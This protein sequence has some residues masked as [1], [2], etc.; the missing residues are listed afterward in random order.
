MTKDV[1]TIDN[2]K[3]DLKKV[4]DFQDGVKSDSRLG[5]IIPYVILSV[6]ICFLFGTLIFAVIGAPFAGYEITKYASELKALKVARNTLMDAADR[7]DIYIS[8]ETLSHISRE[9]V[10]EPRVRMGKNISLKEASIYHFES[11]RSWRDPLFISD[12]AMGHHYEWS[13]EYRISC[14][15]LDNISVKGNE[16]YFISLQMSPD[17]TYIYPTKFFELSEELKGKKE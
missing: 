3:R 15:G 12:I 16:F 8:L 11:G 4:I 9:S 14:I 6:A 10:Y 17:V 1:L 2:V 5:Y 7:G 13:S